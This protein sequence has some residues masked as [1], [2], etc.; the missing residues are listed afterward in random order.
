M[1][2]FANA[3][4]YYEQKKT[5]AFKHEKTIEASSKALKSAERKIRQDLKETKITATI[6]KIRKPFWFEKFLWFVSTEGHLVIAG[7]DMQQNETLVKRYLAKDDAYVHADLHG[8]ASVIVKNKPN[9][10]GQPLPPSTLYQAGIM[11]VCQSKAWDAKMVTSAYWVYSDQVSKSAPS[12]EYLTTGSF[13]IRGKKNFLPPVQ[14]VY[15]FGYVFKLDES[16]VGNHVRPSLEEKEEDKQENTP[17]TL[18]TEGSA[19]GHTEP[20]NVETAQHVSVENPSS[21]DQPISDSDSEDSS[22]D[23]EDAFPDTQ[24]EDL[25]INANE[26][27]KLETDD[28]YNLDDYGQ[29]SDEQADKNSQEDNSNA[30]AKKFITAKER[31]VMKKNNLTEVTEEIKLQQQQQQKQKQPKEQKSVSAKPKVVAP[32]APSRGRKGKAKKIKEKYADQDE[33]ERQLRMELLAVSCFAFNDTT[34]SSPFFFLLV[35]QRTPTKR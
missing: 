10:N 3:R 26:Q 4:K 24:L 32:P 35:Q 34:I 7:R 29:D 21:I 2:A 1:T 25:N 28:K 27:R 11:S 8:A 5:T 23:E 19:D 9:A 20:E 18:E 17:T 22:S 33:E 30:S 31:R 15:G 6:N 13:M 14:L 16:S 12:G